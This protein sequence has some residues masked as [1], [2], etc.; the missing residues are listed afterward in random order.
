M[1]V[2]AETRFARLS[3]QKAHDLARRIQGMK[4]SDALG[5][6]QFSERKAAQLLCKTLKSAIANAENNAKL[7][8]DDLFVKQAVVGHGPSIKRFWPT[9]RGSASPIKKRMSHIRV[10]LSDGK[11]S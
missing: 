8:A 11:E 10:T 4:V 2:S 5:A 9:A 7:S 1:D 3:A 6:I